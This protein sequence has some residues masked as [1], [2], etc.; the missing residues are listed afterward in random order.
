M[1]QRVTEHEDDG[2]LSDKLQKPG[3]PVAPAPHDLQRPGVGETQGHQRY[4]EGQADGEDQSVRHP[5]L[6]DAYQRTCY[7]S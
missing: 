5:T 2:Y 1:S 4:Y 3:E 6:H 7:S